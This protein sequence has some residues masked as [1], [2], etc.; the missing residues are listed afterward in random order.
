MTLV[1]KWLAAYEE[2]HTK[3][4]NRALHWACV[5]VFIA[6]L[7]GLLWSAPVPE[8]FGRSSGVLNWG[9][10]FIMAA[11]VYYFILSISLALGMLPFVLAV[12]LAISELN[13][14]ETPLWLISAFGLGLAAT[15]QFVGHLLE[16]GRAS[17]IRDLHY[18]VIG[19]LWVLAAV[20]RRLGIPY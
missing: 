14:L 18:V 5:P 11:V 19:P 12:V 10:L 9:T 4:L 1:D 20:Y 13:E 2:G 8:T 6:S 16:G 3:H 15:G 17:L 7:I